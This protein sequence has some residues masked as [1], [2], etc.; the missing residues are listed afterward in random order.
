MC[1]RCVRRVEHR[2][3][4]FMSELLVGLIPRE[5]AKLKLLKGRD[6]CLSTNPLPLFTN[7]FL[8]TLGKSKELEDVRFSSPKPE[9][10]YSV[11]LIGRR[12]GSR[13]RGVAVVEDSTIPFLVPPESGQ[14]DRAA[15]C[16]HSTDSSRPA[17]MSSTACSKGRASLFRTIRWFLLNI[18]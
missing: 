17:T 8:W 3:K 15:L 10:L 1:V 5:P 7:E 16:V 6:L 4:S 13:A 11:G 14:V 2:G 9:E 12:L 18:L